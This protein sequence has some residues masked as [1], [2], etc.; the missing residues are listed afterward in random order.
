MKD[1]QVEYRQRRHSTAY[2]YSRGGLRVR[3]ELRGW[4]ISPVPWN[5]GFLAEFQQNIN[6][7]NKSIY[8]WH[9]FDLKV[10]ESSQFLLFW[11]RNY[12]WI[13]RLRRSDLWA[14][15]EENALSPEAT[16]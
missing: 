13:P 9:I 5:D 10:I 3:P 12:I 16:G 1:I 4:S 6:N 15:M 11:F 8:I 2:E 14:G 7:I